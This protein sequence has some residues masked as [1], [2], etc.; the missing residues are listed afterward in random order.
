MRKILYTVLAVLLVAS[1]AQAQIF[2]GGSGTG[3]KTAADCNVAAYFAI[4]TLCQD[5]G[6]AKLYK[7]TGA[8]V[9]ELSAGTGG[10][11]VA[12]T[13]N[14]TWG[15]GTGPVV[16]TYSV[17]G[18]DPTLTITAGAFTLNTSLALGA[19]DLTM[20]GSLGAT[21]A[22][23]TKIWAAAAEF[24]AYPTVNGAAV[25]DQD[26]SA[27]GNPSFSTINVVGANS[28]NLGTAGSLVGGIRFKNATSGYIEVLPA[29]GALGTAG[30]TLPA[31]T[32]TVTVGPTS[33]TAGQVWTATATAGLGAWAN[34]G[35]I[36]GYP[37]TNSMA[38]WDSA[39]SMAGAAVGN[40]KPVCTGAAGIP[41]A[42]AGTEGT[43]ATVGQQ[44][45]LGTS[46]IA[47]NRGSGALTL[48]GITLTTPDIGAATGT[49]LLVTGRVDGTVS[50]VLSTANAATTISSTSNKS[51]Y[52]MNR[53]DSDAHSIY[54]LPT[55][56]EGLQY[57]A[58]NYTGITTVVTFQTSA[59][60]QYI[61]LDG[62]N[63]ASG[64]FIHSD[65]AAGVGA[66]VIGVD[67]THWVA[68]PNKGSWTRD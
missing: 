67:A 33:T 8:A 35:T 30:I 37:A 7:G 49:S 56:A 58:K 66:C 16:W 22:R 46:Q 3:V 53:G 20:T 12:A 6:T 36:T 50:V 23:L 18:T 62:T 47:I 51:A 55:A 61:D 57:C 17:T 60:G 28:L 40:S 9:V 38:Y 29:T 11:V 52:Y 65:A 41:V 48:A 42:C 2:G 44:F 32:G 1:S 31:Q 21:A 10:D 27:D 43:W 26:V 19:N 34:V 13:V 4:G 14:Q 24:T 15:N 25:F 68:Y 63:S 64:G 39:T 45:Y 59:S 54:T 5:T